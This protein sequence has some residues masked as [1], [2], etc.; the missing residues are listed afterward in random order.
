VTKQPFRKAAL[1][2]QSLLEKLKSQGLII[3][4]DQLALR[5]MAYV[6]HFRLKG[7]WFHL[8][9]P[10]TK[11]FLPGTRFE[12]IYE[13][14]ECDR[15]IRAVVMESAERLEVAVR[16][17][18]CNFLS[19]KYSPHWF[20]DSRIFAPRGRSGVGQ[21]LS[22]IEAEIERA[23]SRRYIQ[24][25]Y[26]RYDDPYL[27]P[28]WAMSE[29]VTLGTWS[30]IFAMLRD[31]ADRRVI[32]SKFG[33]KQVEVFESWLHTLTVLRNMAAH[34][35]RFINVRIGV[36]P[37]NLKLKRIKFVDNKSVYASL[38]VMHVLLSAIGFDEP[39]KARLAALEVRYGSFNFQ[40][41]GFTDGWQVNETGWRVSQSP[42]NNSR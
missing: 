7:Y 40:R 26:R 24:A 4:N 18:I 8:Q 30:K 10:S 15:E 38:T 27:P 25:Y 20:L 16:S 12:E 6:G 34:H 29:C 23:G 17:V 35:D 1:T 28:S 3:C 21:V 36:S 32:A 33:I 19:L 14:Y 41:M 37:T 11:Q 31:P 2:P 39:F 9:D 13:H 22:K 42:T 5:C